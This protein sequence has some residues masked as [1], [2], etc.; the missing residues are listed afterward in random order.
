MLPQQSNQQPVQEEPGR[1]GF[2]TKQ[3]IEAM[4]KRFTSRKTPCTG[5]VAINLATLL[6]N[7][8]QPNDD[9]ETIVHNTCTYMSN[10]SLDLAE[11]FAQ[12]KNLP[13][14]IIFYYANAEKLVPDAFRRKHNGT[15]DLLYNEALPI[16]LDRLRSTND[17]SHNGTTA[18]VCLAP[19]MRL[20]SY[21]GL[22]DACNKVADKSVT[23][24]LISHHPMDWHIFR[25]GRLGV[26]Y[27]SHT[28]AMIDMNA[29][30]LGKI[31]FDEPGIPFYPTTHIM[32][33]DKTMI[34]G[35]LLR[36]ERENF[37]ERAK[38]ERFTL[39]SEFY[40]ND[41][42]KIHSSLLPYRLD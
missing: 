3:A 23:L 10:I 29:V 26:L 27:R 30:E 25:T 37:I 4:L 13:H 31:V 41:K 17:Q 22:A 35:I 19:T 11:V 12:W 5:L 34:K 8:I 40:L 32:L 6:R 9:V 42:L 20:P 28:G 14:H 15:T 39:H 33:G 18:V 7:S 38:R 16:L 1:Y 24:H 36:K 2:G 21:K